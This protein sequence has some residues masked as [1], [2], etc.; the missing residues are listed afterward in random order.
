MAQRDLTKEVMYEGVKTLVEA[1]ADHIHLP[2]QKLYTLFSLAFNYLLF[3][4]SKKPGHYIIRVEDSYLLEK[5]MR[6]S[7][8]QTSRK[9]LQKLSLPRKFKYG[10][11]IFHLD[12][13]NLSTWANTN[14]IPKEKIQ[15]ALI[16]KNAHKSP[17]GH[18]FS[19][20][21]DEAVLETLKSLPANYYLSSLQEF[22]PKT[23]AIAFEEEFDKSQKIKFPFIK[24]DDSQKTVKGVSIASDI[25][26]DEI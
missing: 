21:E 11:A 22:V 14:E 4:S 12:F 9:F 15:A 3:M 26:I 25:N 16:V 13:F 8:D 6:K 10:N 7:K 24:E 18:D 23:I 1:E 2:Q 19:D 5:L 20:I 17:I